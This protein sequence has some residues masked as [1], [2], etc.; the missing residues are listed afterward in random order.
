MSAAAAV[1]FSVCQVI[2]GEADVLKAN[3]VKTGDG[4]YHFDVTLRHGD[5]GWDHYADAWEI[6]GPD[7][8]VLG[9]RVLYHPH[10]E[11]QPFTRS[12]G[13]VKIPATVGSVRIRAHDKVHGYG[14]A[15]IDVV[16][17]E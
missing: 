8:A 16:L 6:L 9:K 14:G 5:T 3:V 4:V 7:G 13:N 11:E 15:E 2:A 1:L 12:L 10:V 17:P